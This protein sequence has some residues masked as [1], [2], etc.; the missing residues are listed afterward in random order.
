[1]GV[2]GLKEIFQ[3]FVD[4]VEWQ[5][6]K[7]GTRVLIDGCGWGFHLL[8]HTPALDRHHG[9]DYTELKRRVADFIQT[10]RSNGLIPEVWW[11]GDKTKCKS[12][13]K[14]ERKASRLDEER[15]LYQY[16]VDGLHD[17]KQESLPPP[18][19]FLLQIQHTLRSLKVA[20]VKCEYEADS[21]MAA[22][23]FETGSIVYA[24]DSDFLFMKGCRYVPFGCIESASN[25]EFER[26]SSEARLLAK[27]LT[28][29]ALAE[30][31]GVNELV[32]VE[33]A[34]FLGND[35]TGPL[36]RQSKN[37][38]WNLIPLTCSKPELHK[39]LTIEPKPKGK[40]TSSYSYL[41]SVLRTLQDSLIVQFHRAGADEDCLAY[42]LSSHEECSSS[43]LNEAIQFSRC[44]YE[45]N[46]ESQMN[47]DDD[48]DDDIEDRDIKNEYDC[49]LTRDNLDQ[50][51]VTS[52]KKKTCESGSSSL[53]RLDEISIGQTVLD[54]FKD[55]Q[56]IKESFHFET[57]R[58]MLK[59]LSPTSDSAAKKVSATILN[60]WNGTSMYWDDVEC[61]RLYQ[62]SCRKLLEY[63][64]ESHESL[65]YVDSPASLYHGPTF[66]ALA[67]LCRT[68]VRLDAKS[69]SNS[70]PDV[71]TSHLDSSVEKPG[72]LPID[73]HKDD[74]LNHVNTHRVTILVGETGSGKSSRVPAILL[75]N[76]AGRPRRTKMFVSQPRRIA[77]S[78][79]KQRVAQR[80]GVRIGLRLGNGVRDE[81]HRHTQIWYCTAGYLSRL[82]FH[83]PE[84]FATHTHLVID[85]IHERSVD[86]DLLC[87]M[88]RRLLQMYS[89]LRLIVMSAT[90]NTSTY[91][92]YFGIPHD[93][94][95]FVGARRFPLT[96]NWLDD[97]GSLGKE[98]AKKTGSKTDSGDTS[99]SLPSVI[100]N[101]AHAL[102]RVMN[103]PGD[104]VG[105]K[106]TELQRKIAFD[107]ARFLGK[108]GRTVLIFVAGLRDIEEF[109]EWFEDF[110]N[111]SSQKRHYKFI[112]MH[113]EI[114]FDEQMVAFN[115][116]DSDL[117][118]PPPVKIVVATNIAESSVTL[119]DCDNV[120]CLG[121]AKCVEYNALRNRVQLVHRWISKAG[122]N[123]RAGRTGRVRPGTVW[124][125][126][127]KDFYQRMDEF[128][129]PELQQTPLE[130]V[131]MQIKSALNSSVVPVLQN[132]ISP[133]D[134][135][136]L[137]PAF[138]ELYR[139]GF[140][141]APNDD[142]ELTDDGQVAASL[143]IDLKVAYFLLLGLRLGIPKESAAVAAALC[144]D[145]SPFRI[146]SALVHTPEEM[147][148][149]VTTV[150]KGKEFFDCG[151]YS[152]PMM[153]ARVLRWYLS[154]QENKADK[155]H[156][157]QK[158]KLK[159]FG[160][161]S[162]RVKRLST[163]FRSIE[164]KLSR[165]VQDLEK[166]PFIDIGKNPRA[167]MLLRL[168][169]LWSFTDQLFVSESNVTSES[170]SQQ[171]EIRL[172]GDTLTTDILTKILK[173]NND[174][175]RLSCSLIVSDTYNYKPH[176]L[177]EKDPSITDLCKFISHPVFEMAELRW[178]ESPL[179]GSTI[180][181][182]MPS[183]NGRGAF[184]KEIHYELE[185]M[186]GPPRL[187]HEDLVT[188][189][190]IKFSGKDFL[191]YECKKPPP[192]QF[193]QNNKNDGRNQKKRTNSAF[194]ISKGQK[195]KMKSLMAKLEATLHVKDMGKGKH[196]LISVRGVPNCS[197]E[198]LLDYF[199]N[200]VDISVAHIK[201]RQRIL[202]EH[203]DE[204]TNAK[205]ND[206]VGNDLPLIQDLPLNMRILMFLA[207][208]HHGKIL[209]DRE[210]SDRSIVGGGRSADK[211]VKS[212]SDQDGKQENA[213]GRIKISTSHVA[214]IQ[215]L[216]TEVL[217]Q[218][219]EFDV[220]RKIDMRMDKMS[221]ESVAYNTVKS[222]KSE[223]SSTEESR[224]SLECRVH[225]MQRVSVGVAASV[226]AVG[227]N[228]S[229][230][231]LQQ[232][233]MM[234]PG[235]SWV[236]KALGCIGVSSVMTDREGDNHITSGLCSIDEDEVLHLMQ[237]VSSCL[238]NRSDTSHLS[239]NGFLHSVT[240]GRNALGQPQ[241]KLIQAVELLFNLPE[242]LKSDH[243]Q[244]N[245][246]E[247]YAA[248]SHSRTA[249]V[250]ETKVELGAVQTIKLQNSKKK[251][252]Y[253]KRAKQKSK[254]NEAKCQKHEEAR[255]CSRSAETPEAKEID[256]VQ[257]TMPQKSKKKR[258]RKKKKRVKQESKQSEAKLLERDEVQ[259]CSRS[260]ETPEAEGIDAVQK[261]IPQ[262]SKKNRKKVI[263]KSKKSL[264]EANVPE[265][266]EARSCSR[267]AESPE[268]K[269]K[270][271][272]VQKIK[273]HSSKMKKKKKTK[274]KQ[275]SKQNLTEAKVPEGRSVDF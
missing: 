4:K 22:D 143:G 115:T 257:K 264:V 272:T 70:L 225:E 187:S 218:G 35:F 206:L 259:S 261:R 108:P 85:E 213:Y 177:P 124:R 240:D 139:M 260:A 6:L 268:T 263:Q 129:P 232:C 15:R 38:C 119:P 29:R 43:K 83:H 105:K 174:D 182:A 235:I 173:A 135:R 104:P 82:A 99:L 210:E 262:K 65:Q 18:P 244:E 229:L 136:A 23:S 75:E 12:L 211:N 60:K 215:F 10:L 164:M 47:F 236:N 200:C 180:F 252:K 116:I 160:L 194:S 238:T 46:F 181:L 95:I 126:Y 165:H 226:L 170:D 100:T 185:A 220:K 96:L 176:F 45:H 102:A 156:Y 30:S 97:F 80:Y 205:V 186:F 142:G 269:V 157:S 250:H 237:I 204:L 130:H 234:P 17:I 254:Q 61:S 56:I 121:T 239:K 199:E 249:E 222:F 101:Q 207:N 122:A 118:G 103:S 188:V 11:D 8:N 114:P 191:A 178:L 69:M 125:L 144:M 106:V 243:E 24:M 166:M 87:Y 27:V 59:L 40:S 137:K 134:L 44:Y 132:V 53:R 245:L 217:K 14:L 16:C 68:Q 120:I 251:T 67:N 54:V 77:A 184:L 150:I 50:V 214:S 148:D 228:Q 2:R 242:A 78:T 31:L 162:A 216:D 58:M 273:T 172:T 147:A 117:Q 146:A 175:A 112:P 74:I 223:T 52:L 62:Q 76:G 159:K 246:Q 92:D 183:E 28:R 86:T 161:V 51:L 141:H 209:F 93:E 179:T 196:K 66:H 265:R 128:D 248:R 154:L 258:K 168:S 189:D 267:S 84:I 111:R 113:S 275:E 33:W 98:K 7:R 127:S 133:P 197:E 72:L 32:L 89:H 256:D 36:I 274:V 221:L 241:E 190:V 55:L 202:F 49:V 109:A 5:P 37:L 26:S 145:K 203:R 270:C 63:L 193:T 266:D 212:S 247:R 48:D 140:L 163:L 131:I 153:L 208:Q 1:M 195:K 91:A 3:D 20:H 13:T 192:M 39:G 233:T 64:D 149:I 255:S 94:F 81:D 90:I 21:Y 224:N 41:L 19:L 138:A 253:E 110:S 79:L 171:Y 227:A 71:I 201:G 169:L 123:Q 73:D 57:I 107:L 151:M 230:M 271:E 42:I 167:R 231:I 9:G 219:A 88:A 152:E 155:R 25:H 34:I 198:F 158:R